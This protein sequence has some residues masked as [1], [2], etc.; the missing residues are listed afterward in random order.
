MS[1]TS[2]SDTSYVETVWDIALS[3]IVIL[4]SFAFSVLITFLVQKVVNR[5]QNLTI[6]HFTCIDTVDNVKLGHLPGPRETSMLLTDVSFATDISSSR[7]FLRVGDILICFRITFHLYFSCL[8]AAKKDAFDHRFGRPFYSCSS[9]ADIIK[10]GIQS[11]NWFDFRNSTLEWCYWALV[12]R[13]ITS[14]CSP[15]RT[16]QGCHW[17]GLTAYIV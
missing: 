3:S 13:Q 8:N 16:C 14:E 7:T 12:C 11:N 2:R 17:C 4:L 1:P 9:Y 5:I 10:L 15:P 6:C